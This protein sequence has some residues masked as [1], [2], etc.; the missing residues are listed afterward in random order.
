MEQNKKKDIWNIILAIP[1]A[2][3]ALGQVIALGKLCIN[4][5]ES[6]RY[7]IS[8]KGILLS[9]FGIGR[10][11]Y[12]AILAIILLAIYGVIAFCIFTQKKNILL[13]ISSAALLGVN[14]I[15]WVVGFFTKSYSVLD[16][17]Y[18]QYKFNV[19]TAFPRLLEILIPLTVLVLV[20]AYTIKGM[21]KFQDVVKKL[22]FVPA[23]VVFL[24]DI[25]LWL[26][27]IICLIFKWRWFGAI[28][29]YGGF[30]F[31]SV[32]DIFGHIIG[33]VV[34]LAATAA[35]GIY[36]CEPFKKKEIVEDVVEEVAEEVVTEETVEE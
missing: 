34:M 24:H 20:A 16:I 7:G 14:F 8:F 15:D 12:G 26:V 10:F 1:F 35:L 33:F 22:W 11:G 30:N 23:A 18:Y 19:I 29:V 13:L 2:L 6:L 25:T 5:I 17:Q 32:L 3:L 31:Q 9:I 36:L 21:D 28:F 27:S 4:F